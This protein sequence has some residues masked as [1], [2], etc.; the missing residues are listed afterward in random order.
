[1]G[2]LFST[3]KGGFGVVLFRTNAHFNALSQNICKNP[4]TEQALLNTE[5]KLL[6]EVEMDEY[7]AEESEDEWKFD[8][9]SGMVDVWEVGSLSLSRSSNPKNL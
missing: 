3:W 5:K 9:P 1:M 7:D 8:K 4:H 6:E 2:S